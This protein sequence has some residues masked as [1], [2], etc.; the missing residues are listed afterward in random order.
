[1]PE[2][3]TIDTNEIEESVETLLKAEW[4]P[5]D[6]TATDKEEWYGYRS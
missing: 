5:N 3:H 1:M 2:I 6:T 4:C